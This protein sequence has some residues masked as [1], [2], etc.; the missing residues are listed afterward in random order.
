[1]LGLIEILCKDSTSQEKYKIFLM[2]PL[3]DAAAYFRFLNQN[4]A[5]Q[6]KMFLLADKKTKYA[7]FF[8]WIIK[9][10]LYLSPRMSIINY[11]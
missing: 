3:R 11:E 5:N 4:S 6:A 8:S 7:F 1:M 10:Y 9:K 2:H